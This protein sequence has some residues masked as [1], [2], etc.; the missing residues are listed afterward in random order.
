M[1]EPVIDSHQNEGEQFD[2]EANNH[3]IPDNHDQCFEGGSPVPGLSQVDNY[4]QLK[5]QAKVKIYHEHDLKKK[6]QGTHSAFFGHTI[7]KHALAFNFAF[8]FRAFMFCFAVVFGDQWPFPFQLL[9]VLASTTIYLGIAL[10]AG[11]SLWEDKMVRYQHILNEF[12]VTTAAMFHFWFSDHVDDYDLR[13]EIGVAF[14]VMIFLLVLANFGF[15]VV[16]VGLAIR[17]KIRQ[18]QARL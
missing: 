5:R 17:D 7:S 15:V 2:Q 12:V 9:L 1:P 6:S 14:I 10:D 3:S 8:A 4:D 13:Q 18:R 16:T 11:A